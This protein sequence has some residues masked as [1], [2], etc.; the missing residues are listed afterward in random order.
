[1]APEIQ[2]LFLLFPP[3][4]QGYN[5]VWTEK[6]TSPVIFNMINVAVVGY[7][8]WGPNL[9]RNFNAL[10]GCRLAAV[11]E[12]NP[13]RAEK[14][15]RLYP[16]VRVTADCGAVMAD[17]DISAVVVSTPVSTHYELV[18]EALAAGKDVLAGKPLA[19]TAAEARELIGLAER[20][21]RVLAVDHTYLYTGAVR[22]IAQ[23]TDSGDL[24]GIMYIDS[25]RVNLGI[26]QPDVNVIYD[27]A[28][29]DISIAC[30]LLDRDPET[31]RALGAARGGRGFEYLAY[32]HLDYGGGL[33]AHFHLNWLSPIKIRRTL[34]A[35]SRKMV[36]YDDMEQSEKVK[37]YDRGVTIKEGDLD[38]IYNT[39][40]DYRTGDMDAPKLD[41][42]EALAVEA[43]HFIDCVRNRSRPDSDGLSA[44]RVVRIIEAAQLSIDRNGDKIRIGAI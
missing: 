7:G 22:R 35:G 12:T 5:S 27:L 9:A 16:G 13:A 33:A 24:G 26:F 36:V 32:L 37:V 39:Y 21:G 1:M 29:H 19:R 40:V 3:A 41:T 17:P 23:L 8:Y 44:L 42:R 28:P 2:E 31:V 4:P 38:S 18:R 30:R 43:E 14:A 34:I 25:V 20:N 11:C 15:A 6:G 10:D